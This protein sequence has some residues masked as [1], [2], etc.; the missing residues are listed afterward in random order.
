[1]LRLIS[2]ILALCLVAFS[3]GA[4]SKIHA[5]TISFGITA[6]GDEATVNERSQIKS[7]VYKIERL[8]LDNGYD[9]KFDKIPILVSTENP[10]QSHW[11]GLCVKDEK[12]ISQYI[13]I[14][15]MVFEQEYSYPTQHYIF[16]VLLHEIGHCYFNREHDLRVVKKP[17]YLIMIDPYNSDYGPMN[18]YKEFPLSIMYADKDGSSPFLGVSE[19]FENYF[20]MELLGLNKLLSFDD[21]SS[22]SGVQI[23]PTNE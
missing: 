5:T 19:Q 2:T 23:V 4:C 11:W 12:N 18:I 9:G 7:T 8:A 14:N 22:F 15:R 10:K 17:G 21:L 3:G 16:G 1:M 6:P 20:V 13:L